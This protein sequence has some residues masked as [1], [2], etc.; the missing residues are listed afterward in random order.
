MNAN[1]K[2]SVCVPHETVAGD[3]VAGKRNASG[4]PKGAPYINAQC[5]Q[6]APAYPNDA[7]VR[8]YDLLAPQRTGELQIPKYRL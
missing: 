5:H 2:P 3:V 6:D 8:I 7:P 4:L 1:A